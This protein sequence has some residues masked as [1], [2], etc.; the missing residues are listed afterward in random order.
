ML[1]MKRILVLLFAIMAFAGCSRQL[2]EKVVVRYPS[3]QPQKVCYF[4]R[5]GD[6]VKEAEFYDTG[7]L[8]MEGPMKDGERHGE[9][10]AYFRDGRVQSI[11]YF[12]NGVREG[13]STVYRETGQLYMEG[14]YKAGKHCGKWKY[15]DEQGYLLR[16]DD[17]G[18]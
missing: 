15:Y 14:R 3:G 16:E 18:E 11:G 8:Y 6:C 4:D 17:Y 2:K 13:A 7:A 5:S 9:W 10:L 1:K 12:E